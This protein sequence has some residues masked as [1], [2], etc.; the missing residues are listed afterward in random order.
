VLPLAAI[1]VEAQ[2]GSR[3][4]FILHLAKLT[5]RFE[6]CLILKEKAKVGI[7]AKNLQDTWSF[8][9]LKIPVVKSFCG[10]RGPHIYYP[11]QRFPMIRIFPDGYFWV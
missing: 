1:K 4:Q 7:R 3:N 11:P 10:G 6:N 9:S 8:G 2:A 5:H